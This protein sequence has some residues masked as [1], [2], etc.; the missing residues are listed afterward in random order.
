MREL[1]SRLVD[2]LRRDRLERELADEMRFHHEQAERDAL[3]EGASA[4]EAPWVARRRFGNAA[5][6]A[7][8][9]RDRWSLPWL[10]H[11]QQDVRYGLRGLRRSPGF[12]ATA[13]ITLALGIGANV[14][15]FGVVDRLMFR[16]YAYLRDPETV[17]RVYLRAT[18]RGKEDWGYGG[19]YTRYLD[20]RRFTTSFSRLSGFAHQTLAVGT[21]DASRERGV[22]TVSASFWEFFDG[23]PALGR[24]FVASEDSTPRGAEVAV[25]GEAFW[26]TEMG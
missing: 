8:A 17:H 5:S 3:A 6:V 20:L 22:A 24:Y 19:E 12:T 1:L 9:S 23:R 15:M 2:W 4:E 18:Y 13:V 25:L 7:E 11:L 16:P 10:D 26:K 21:G 14:A